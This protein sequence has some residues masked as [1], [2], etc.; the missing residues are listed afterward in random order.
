MLYWMLSLVR[1]SSV[2]FRFAV[3]HKLSI[4]TK[5]EVTTGGTNK[6]NGSAQ[7]SSAWCYIVRD[8]TQIHQIIQCFFYFISSSIKFRF[9]LITQTFTIFGTNQDNMMKCLRDK[10]KPILWNEAKNKKMFALPTRKEKQK[11]KHKVVALLK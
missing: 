10:Q 5:R 11:R 6:Y 9:V 3:E 4:E 1:F 7:F 8:A 2:I